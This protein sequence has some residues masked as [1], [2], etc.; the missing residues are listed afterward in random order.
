[1]KKYLLP[2]LLIPT[3]ALSAFAE[4]CSQIH[5]NTGL[6][7][8]LMNPVLQSGKCLT[9]KQAYDKVIG[10]AL[11]SDEGM[12]GL[13]CTP[14]AQNMRGCMKAANDPTQGLVH[15]QRADG[16][17]SASLV[18][19]KIGHVPFSD[20]ERPPANGEGVYRAD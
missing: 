12:E 17:R 15:Q 1:M 6:T 7:L 9:E 8:N 4:D 10:E 13:N 18:N 20:N 14:E 16:E 5:G 2:I 3:F 19:Q 11:L